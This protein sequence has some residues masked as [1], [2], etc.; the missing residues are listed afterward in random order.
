MKYCS[1]LGMY[2]KF[3]YQCNPGTRKAYFVLVRC[4]PLPW[5]DNVYTSHYTSDPLSTWEVHCLPGYLL[6][7]GG[8][9]TDMT[10]QDS[11]TWTEAESCGTLYGVLL[12]LLF[13]LLLWLLFL[14]DGIFIESNFMLHC[15]KIQHNQLPPYINPCWSWRNSN[16][17]NHSG[18][19]PRVCDTLHPW[20]RLWQW[21]FYG[22]G[23]VWQW[24]VEL[25]W[26]SP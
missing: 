24:N 7:D 17:Y 9:V 2:R 3:M 6:L 16:L 26:V 21:P 13:T 14:K 20:P 8:T 4:P 22:R 23:H 10:C 11:L 15:R 1:I 5:I 18:G 19:D 12:M 25:N